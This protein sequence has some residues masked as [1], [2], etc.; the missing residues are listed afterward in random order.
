[1][2][3]E[4]DEKNNKTA[5]TGAKEGERRRLR[6]GFERGEREER[7]RRHIDGKGRK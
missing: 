4:R 2:K 6:D 1:M 5:E 7:G 3:E